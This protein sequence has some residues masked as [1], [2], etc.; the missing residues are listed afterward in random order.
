VKLKEKQTRTFLFAAQGVGAIFVAIFLAAYFG[1]LPST[2]TLNSEQSFIVSQTIVGAAFIAFVFVALI[3][4][5]ITKQ[6]K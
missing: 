2:A 6:K 5:F 4:A 1:G 3:L